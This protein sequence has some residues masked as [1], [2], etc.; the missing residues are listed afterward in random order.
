MLAAR[1]NDMI[2]ISAQGEIK[3]LYTS[4]TL[5]VNEPRLISAHPREPVIPSHVDLS[6][7]TG[8]VFLTDTYIGRNLKGLKKGSVKKL[9]IMEQL[10]K[11]VNYHGGG[12]TPLAHGG[13]WTIDRILGTVPVESDGSACFEAPAGRSLFLT[14]LDENGLAIKQMRSFMTVMPGERVSCIG[15]HEKADNIA[16]T[17]R[18]FPY[19]MKG[20][21]V[22]CLPADGQPCGPRGLSAMKMKSG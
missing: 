15:C 5:P 6:K 19:A 22:S 9:L 3:V 11:P 13:K 21:P 16:T 7:T 18:A 12:S 1:G 20:E 14:L 4:T 2:S 8:T 10:P 17:L